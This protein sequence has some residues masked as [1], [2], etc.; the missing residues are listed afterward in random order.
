M[1]YIGIFT[2]ENIQ[3]TLD[4]VYEKMGDSSN[5]LV[6]HLDSDGEASISYVKKINGTWSVEVVGIADL[7]DGIK[8]DKEHLKAQAEILAKW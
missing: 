4:H 5:G 7:S 1:P 8:F 3:K 2:E 6:A